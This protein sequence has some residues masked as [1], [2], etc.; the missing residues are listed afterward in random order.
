MLEASD[1]HK[2]VILDS[3]SLS[4]DAGGNAGIDRPGGTTQALAY[5]ILLHHDGRIYIADVPE[6]PGCMGTGNTYAEALK[7]AENAIAAWLQRARRAGASPPALWRPAQLTSAAQ[8]CIAARRSR[9][10]PSRLAPERRISPVKL[11][12]VQKFGKMSNRELARRIGLVERDA[13][14]M[15]SAAASGKGT[16]RARCA[17]ALALNE[18]PSRL[19]PHRLPRICQDDDELYVTCKKTA[20]APGTEVRQK[21]AT[22]PAAS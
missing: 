2:P 4:A 10:A 12:L 11:A 20:A 16:R 13:P 6:L 3:T 14:T 19:W 5:C 17:I 22:A 15:L 21:T 7:S 18:L 8:D 1:K 9:L